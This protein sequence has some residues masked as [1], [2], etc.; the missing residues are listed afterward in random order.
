MRISELHEGKIVYRAEL[1]SGG[2]TPLIENP[3]RQQF[4]L[5]LQ[6]SEYDQLRCLVGQSVY[7]GAAE[8]WTHGEMAAKLR[9]QAISTSNAE[10]GF[11]VDDAALFWGEA[12]IDD[13]P[14]DQDD[15]DWLA[16]EHRPVVERLLANRHLMLLYPTVPRLC[17]FVNN[18]LMVT[19]ERD[20]S[21][22]LTAI[23]IP[24]EN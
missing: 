13:V 24:L 15:V 8:H 2:S 20:G 16:A 17:F 1:R 23:D 3:S 5:L 21:N 6:E 18:G 4:Q 19:F 12:E 7:V 10:S 22:D 14:P 11:L 9:Q